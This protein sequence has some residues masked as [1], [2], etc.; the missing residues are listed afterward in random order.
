MKIISKV[1]GIEVFSKCKE[2]LRFWWT[3]FRKFL[4]QYQQIQVFTTGKK[5]WEVWI[6]ELE[7]WLSLLLEADFW[8]LK[9]A[10]LK[11]SLPVHK[12][13]RPTQNQCKWPKQCFDMSHL[14]PASTIPHLITPKLLK[15]SNVQC[16]TIPFHRQLTLTQE[17]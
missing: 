6:Q 14:Y 3:T 16:A 9:F 12:S 11:I 15:C 10:L 8:F 17:F 13:P 4:T 5:V 2:P 7:A 1:E